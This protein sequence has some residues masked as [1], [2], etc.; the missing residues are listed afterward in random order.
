M[1]RTATL[2]VD[3]SGSVSA[4]YGGDPGF[5][6]L[7]T[8]GTY[9]GSW[10][11]HQATTTK[12]RRSGARSSVETTTGTITE[13][14]TM[15]YRNYHG[16]VEESFGDG[17]GSG[18]AT[19]SDRVVNRSASSVAPPRRNQRFLVTAGLHLR[20]HCNGKDHE[21]PGVGHS[22]QPLEAVC[23]FSCWF[24]AGQLS[25]TRGDAKTHDSGLGRHTSSARSSAVVRFTDSSRPRRTRNRLPDDF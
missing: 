18:H 3:V 5:D 13:S 14:S 8:F 17:C 24:P 1:V 6:G 15:H 7:G 12:Y 21:I 10:N 25:A 4:D 11:W 16:P 22:L 9:S 23:V 19:Q 20:S 2:S